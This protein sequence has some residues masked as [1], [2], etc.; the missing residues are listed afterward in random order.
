MA[1][2]KHDEKLMVWGCFA[3]NG[4]GDLH[5]VKGI[6]LKEQYHQILQKHMRPSAHRLFPDK[7]YIFQQDNDPKHT[8]HIIR[9]YIA[10]QGIETFDWPAQSPDLNPIENL[11]GE[12]DRQLKGR[13]VSTLPE[14]LEALKEGWN[15]LEVDLL[16]KLVHSMP[17]RCAAVIKAN[18]YAT[19]Y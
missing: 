15:N 2:V 19:K 17:R 1:T 11:W 3:A 14:L 4:V 8:A 18:G 13:K 10:N 12:L 7:N 9:D 6:M 16:R 5:M